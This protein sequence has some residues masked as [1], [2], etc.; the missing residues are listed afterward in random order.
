[1]ILSGPPLPIEGGV[2]D[3][4]GSVRQR[5]EAE[6]WLLFKQT[7]GD[8][9]RMR[10]DDTIRSGAALLMRGTKCLIG[11]LAVAA[12]SSQSASGQGQADVQKYGVGRYRVT[13]TNLTRGQQFTP[14]LVAT[15]KKGLSLFTLGQPA[16]KPLIPL[17]E[18]G[19]TDPLANYIRGLP[20]VEDFQVISGFLSPGASATTTV[21]M[22]GAFDHVSVASMLIPTD[23]GFLAANDVAGPSGSEE[24]VLFS[25]AYD[26]GSKK[27]DELCSSI[28]GPFFAE[29]GGPGGGGSVVGGNEG[30]VHIHAGIH[31]IGNFASAN[32]D[33]RNPVAKNTITRAN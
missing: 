31:G 26:A 2:N 10:F 21:V 4:F 30:Y 24:I 15:H 12:V 1:L 8:F 3:C 32:R 28:P 7:E 14:V 20:E 18:L 25:P 9:L 17:A 23:D 6:T 5:G 22:R 33:W 27:N 16:P 19:Q 13:V 29:C 11:I